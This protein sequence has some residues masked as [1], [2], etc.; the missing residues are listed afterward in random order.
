MSII[1][2]KYETI[3]PR[4][5]YLSDEVI[6]AQAWKKSHSY[7]R[8][9][10]WYA[11]ILELD[12]STIDLENRIKTWAKNLKETLYEVDAMR[13]VL[14][15]KNKQWHFLESKSNEPF[16]SWRPERVNEEG[17]IIGQKLRPLAH[18]SIKDQTISTAVMLCLA[19]AVE[20][21]QGPTDESDFLSAQ[22]QQIFSYGNRLHCDWETNP[23]TRKQAH[24]GWGNSRC[25]RQYYEDYKTFLLRPKSICQHYSSIIAPNKNLYVVSLDLKEFYDHIDTKALIRELKRLYHSYSAEFNLGEEL[26]DDESKDEKA[27][28]EKT[29]QVF[30]WHWANSD[31][32]NANIMSVEELPKGLPQGLTASGFYSNAYLIGFDKMVGDRINKKYEDNA[33]LLLDYCRYVDD[34]RLVVEVSNEI[35]VDTVKNSVVDMIN[36][37]IKQYQKKIGAKLPLELNSDKTKV[38]SH[39]Q[40]SNQNSVSSLMN[41]FQSV[42]SGTPDVESLRQAAGGLDGLLRMSD[43]L[44]SDE[45]VT[46]SPLV[47]SKISTPD[48]DVRDD[49]LKRFVAT[50]MVKSLRLRRSMTDL[51]EKLGN[52]DSES[53]NM[54][55]GQMLDHEFETAARKL[56]ACWAG[57][58][59]LS[60]LLRCALDLYPDSLLLTPVIDALKSKLHSPS[61]ENTY[62]SEMKVAE[63]VSADLL[64]AATTDIGYRVAAIYPD[65]ADLPEFREEIASF[66]RELL[67][68]HSNSPWYIK[69]QAILFLISIGDYGFIIDSNIPELTQ[70]AMLQDAALYRTNKA[71]ELQKYVSI[72]LVNQQINPNP[73]RYASWFI[74]MLNREDESENR[75]SAINIVFMNRP[76]LMTEILKS[77]RLMT[78]QWKEEI[79]A[80]IRNAIKPYGMKEINLKSNHK[81]S[82]LRIIQT[83]SNPFKQE[84]ALLLLTQSILRQPDAVEKLKKGATVSDIMVKC[85]DWDEIQN[86]KQNDDF[87]KV[88]FGNIPNSALNQIP[89][90][91][92]KKYSWIYVLGS[93]LR[94]SII[95]NYDYT[96]N[97][98]LLKQDSSS[99]KGV[100]STWFTRRFG[101]STQQRGL[102]SEPSPISPWLSELLIR[103]LQWPGIRQ[104]GELI[105]EFEEV[106]NS[107]DLLSI[108]QNRL[109][110]QSKIFGRLSNTPF[111]TLPIQTGTLGKGG[112]I[113]VAVVQPLLPK[114]SDFNM[115]DPVHWT[116][117]FRALHR[118]HIASICNL[119]NS[120]LKATR[121]AQQTTD[122]SPRGDKDIDLIV[123]P[124][125]TVHPD[126]IDLL[127]GLSDATKA[128]I[129]A[130]LTFIQPNVAK[131]PIN[132]ALWL[133][134]SERPMGRE[135]TY[136]YQGKRHMT[137]SEKKMGIDSYRP[138]Q[139]L[140]E[141]NNGG[142][143][144]TR[145][146]GA[147]CYDATDLSLV[148]DLREVSDLFVIAAM[149]Q[150]VQTFDNMV[151][152][153]H[154]HMYQPVILANTGEFGGSTAQAPFNKYARQ[155]AHIH[156]NHQV[157]V[158]VFEVDPT[159]F[160]GKPILSA[161]QDIK[162]PPAGY[163]GRD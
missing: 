94:S 50:R 100:K 122:L 62:V 25:Y 95:G 6:I 105:D 108:I 28:W 113:Q 7:I 1:N 130:G 44:V 81:L 143:S 51:T 76:D 86:P 114:M 80:D 52:I 83:E 161:P 48:I 41:M 152:A 93:I 78:S 65:S 4:L 27:F 26:S 136:V 31:S 20:T 57:N 139:V 37:L 66:A 21:I 127:R 148:A 49:T 110:Y 133:L 144:K 15:P 13:L 132:Q 99:Y 89:S 125:L 5:S 158:S 39:R 22:R 19:D 134:R 73:K 14:A 53:D 54:T 74:E 30:S 120:H 126:D 103:L 153:L 33:F 117:S 121:A 59:S 162:T 40:L 124:E 137:K 68:H 102:L 163:K 63:Y 90:W 67:E 12:C 3:A 128:N 138:Y 2:E 70:Y 10:N 112:K 47:L 58:P 92:K 88:S 23:H 96:S 157:G 135:F 38:I 17:D 87:L 111:Y 119:V 104:W 42:L 142:L 91:V 149:N 61:Q 145:V 147:I 118:N 55:A 131:P 29:E 159:V 109:T 141:F 11:D 129:F 116:P 35:E 146:T 140:I 71:W 82:L 101:L 34:I 75:K 151:T 45:P 106:R 115:K 43:Q 79:P 150:D 84:N 72:A 60:L 64:R 97:T 56:I 9:H 32:E 154:Y 18:L 98:Y 46:S 16:D 36:D 24:F 8:T 155:I 156:G 123:F 160:K 69:Q 107:G 77:K 85:Q